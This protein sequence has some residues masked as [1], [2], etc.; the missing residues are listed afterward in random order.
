MPKRINILYIFIV[1][2]I[3][4]SCYS[5]EEFSN[6]PS[7][8]FRSL[9]YSPSDVES[10]SLVLNIDFQ[11]GDGDIGL[12]GNE[13][14]SPYHAYN[15]IIDSN[16]RFVTLSNDSASTPFFYAVPPNFAS[17]P[18]DSELQ[19]FS[20]QDLRTSFN[21]QEYEIVEFTDNQGNTFTDTIYVFRNENNKNIFVDFY[22][23]INGQYEFIDWTRVFSAIGCGTNFDARFPVFEPDNNGR[24]LEGTIRYAMVS[25]GFGLV[26][27]N[28]T[29]QIRV[30]IK[31]RDLNGSNI[32]VSPDLTLNDILRQ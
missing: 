3:M 30:R 5:P 21:C 32:A 7:I 15:V 16:N 13:T 9:T 26:L 12:D 18:G 27:R 28:D 31:D 29:F 11:D 1:A 25:D 23:K 20:D 6:T 19:F 4:Q 8:A 14:R 22:R 24:S 10:D 2:L 17:E